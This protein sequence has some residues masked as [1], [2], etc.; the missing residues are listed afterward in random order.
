M[1][2]IRRFSSFT[3]DDPYPIPCAIDDLYPLLLSL[4]NPSI[5]INEVQIHNDLLYINI[6]LITDTSPQSVL[7]VEERET[8]GQK[9]RD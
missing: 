2:L 6:Q 5:R 8:A 7:V 9:V 4:D 1:T 3:I